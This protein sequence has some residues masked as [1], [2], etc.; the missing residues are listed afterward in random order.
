MYFGGNSVNKKT[1]KDLNDMKEV[2][3]PQFGSQYD[4]FFAILEDYYIAKLCGDEQIKG[5]LS[6]WNEEAQ[7]EIVNILADNIE[8]RGL[9]DFDRSDILALLSLD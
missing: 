9:M 7:I 8:A 3:V 4:Y 5:E 1:L 2:S 6:H